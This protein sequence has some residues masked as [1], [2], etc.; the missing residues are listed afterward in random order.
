MQTIVRWCLGNR[1]VVILFG[2]ILIGAGIGATFRLNQELLPNVEFPSAYILTTDPGAGPEVVDR[3][4]TQ[5]LAAALTGLPRARR[6]NTQSSQGFSLVAIQFDLDSSLKDDLDNVNQ[7]LGQL[8]PP[9]GVG[10]P[11]VESFSFSAFPTMTYS[12]VA[13]DG[14]LARATREAK[15]LIAPALQGAKGLAQVKV[16]GGEQDSVLISLDMGKLKATGIPAGQVAQ[17]LAGAQ[18]SLPAGEALDGAKS[19]P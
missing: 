14:D 11:L 10:K 13:T 7:R 9:P 19:V 4:V 6:L 1:P 8:Q 3:D 2:L 16:V 5:P 15:E 12:L 17:A 18:V